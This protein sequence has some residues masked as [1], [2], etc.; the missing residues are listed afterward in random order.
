MTPQKLGWLLFGLFVFALVMG[1]GPGSALI[2]PDPADPE[3]RRFI[4]GMPVVYA[5][6]VLWYGVQAA[7][8]LIAYVKLWRDDESQS[9]AES[10]SDSES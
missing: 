5:W 6:A 7:C 8:V 10:E 2:N 9:P 4:L 1:P 3:A